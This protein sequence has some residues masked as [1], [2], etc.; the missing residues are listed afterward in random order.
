MP[1]RETVL[2]HRKAKKERVFLL[3][4]SAAGIGKEMLLLEEIRYITL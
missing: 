2:K 3:S 1:I 4:T